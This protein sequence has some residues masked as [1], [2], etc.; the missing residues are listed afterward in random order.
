MTSI[1]SSSNTSMYLQLLM[2]INQSNG[3]SGSDGDGDGGIESASVPG[4]QSTS[5]LQALQQSLSQLTS[6]NANASSSDN[7]TQQHA[8]AAIK[9]F[10]QA[11]L[12]ALHQAGTNIGAASSKPSDPDG[13][14]D[15]SKGKVSAAQ[16]EKYKKPNI[17]ADLQALMQQVSSSSTSNTV[18]QQSF[19]NMLTALGASNANNTLDNFLQSL[20]SNMQ[21]A[22][23]LI[24]TTA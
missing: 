24:S 16:A 11:L 13:D 14:N 5:F 10:M 7:A 18:L 21:G 8:Q 20:S 22:S 6:S 3:A 4:S 15:G 19:Q 12:A 2:N 17:Q 9:T 23:S 1:S